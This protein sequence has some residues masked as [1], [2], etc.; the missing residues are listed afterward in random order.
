MK[1]SCELPVDPEDSPSYCGEYGGIFSVVSYTNALCMHTRV[2]EGTGT[3]ECEPTAR[4]PC[5]HIF[6]QIHAETKAPPTKWIGQ[7]VE[8]HQDTK[9]RL[10][11]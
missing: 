11:I 9:L 3:H 7:K 10:R 6:K 5:F 2:T 8:S 4:T 1:A